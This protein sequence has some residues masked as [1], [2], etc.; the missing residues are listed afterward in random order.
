MSI[1]SKLSS[2]DDDIDFRRLWRVG[3]I[4]S[5]VLVA[6]SALAI[7]LRG[8]N[9]GI[10]FE[11]GTSWDVPASD[12]SVE[13]AR[14][15]LRD[16]DEADAKIQVVGRG[17]SRI[18]RVQSA[19]VDEDAVVEIRGVLAEAAGIDGTEI[20]VSTVGPSWGDEITAK[21]ERALVFFFIAITIY[22]AIRLEWKMAIGALVSMIHD[23]VIS[24]GF[25]A[26]F[27]FP[28]TPATV[29]A[30]LTILGY[31]L[32]DTIVV[33]D[34]VQDN[35][36]NLTQSSRRSY[37]DAVSLSLNQVLMRSINTTITSMLPIVAILIVGSGFLGAAVLQEFALALAVGLLFGAYSS[38]F[39]AAPL[40]AWMKEREPRMRELHQRVQARGGPV[41]SG[42]PEAAAAGR[43]P[44][45]V[46]SSTPRP[47]G[48]ST[49]LSGRPIPPRPRK[50]GRRR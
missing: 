2:F 49:G 20:S 1:F 12:L 7:G 14:D 42:A 29:I 31:S 27:Q 47:A 18:V 4:V 11:G 43:A 30:F 23:I 8:L 36:V 13:D 41:T 21:A 50:K 10:D 35:T 37:T 16:L 15:E 48:G 32:Y 19:T 34:R 46:G 28:V 44:A 25:Y 33:F 38:I 39:V 9:F 45:Q 17:D 22:M 3:I 40:V 6:G 26:L 5:V 24:V